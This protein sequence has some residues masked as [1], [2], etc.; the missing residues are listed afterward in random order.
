MHD[1]KN[2]YQSSSK[3]MEFERSG[4]NNIKIE[5]SYSLNQNSFSE[6]SIFKFN[7]IIKSLFIFINKM[8][9]LQ[10]YIFKNLFYK[11]MKSKK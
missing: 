3:I 2:F 10:F 6:S 7:S 5:R 9:F 4:E 11:L 8:I 1:N